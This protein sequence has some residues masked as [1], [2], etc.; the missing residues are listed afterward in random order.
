MHHASG[1]SGICPVFWNFYPK[2]SVMGQRDFCFFLK[3]YDFFLKIFLILSFVCHESEK[4]ELSLKRFKYIFSTHY[5]FSV[6]GNA[7]NF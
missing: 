3:H 1:T 7:V 5:T 2:R 4:S 6:Q